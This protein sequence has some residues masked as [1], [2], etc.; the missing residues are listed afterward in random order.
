MQYLPSIGLFL[1]LMPWTVQADDHHQPLLSFKAIEVT[2]GITMLQGKGGNVGLS[3]G[4]DGMLIVDADYAEMSEALAK[5]LE[6]IGGDRL[7]FV[8]N[9][10]W[11]GDHTGGNP[12]VGK[13]VPIIA[14]ANVRKRVSSDQQ[15]K[16]F[17]QVNK[18]LPKE[19]WP[20]ITFEQ[21]LSLHFNG[22]EIRVMHFPFGHTDGDAVVFFT[23]SKVV[24]M[25]DHF[26]AGRFPFI[27]LEHGGSVEGLIANVGALIEQLPEVVKIIP[28]HGP[29]S[30]LNDL[31]EYHQMLLT[32][33]D[34][35][36]QQKEAE[37]TLDEVLKEGLPKKWNEWGSGF[38]NEQFWI[39]T[40]YNGQ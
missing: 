5:K 13:R 9:T 7:Q 32:T 6:E 2:Q 8:L 14:H 37:K 23:D 24:H 31:R 4:P 3:H 21:G 20:V 25:G 29:L 18:A 28:G 38:V 26:F 30:N 33:A 11:H 16:V 10:H 12:A 39:T 36:L 17:D 22:E 19:G 34:Y 27:D 40:L 1:L 35:V 15:M